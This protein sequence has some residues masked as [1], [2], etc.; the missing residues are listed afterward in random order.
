[1]QDMSA[2]VNKIALTSGICKTYA[3]GSKQDRKG[4]AD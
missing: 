2:G 4:A 1:M 3:R